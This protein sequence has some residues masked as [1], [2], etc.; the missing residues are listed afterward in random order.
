MNYL[1]KYKEY[2]KNLEKIKEDHNK[3]ILD[4]FDLYLEDKFQIIDRIREILDSYDDEID[5]VS[6]RLDGKNTIFHIYKK[7]I[8]HYKSFSDFSWTNNR[9]EK[10]ETAKEALSGNNLMLYI[11]IDSSSTKIIEINKRII[12]EFKS[13]LI[14]SNYNYNSKSNKFIRYKFR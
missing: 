2:V 1:E 12:S 14:L 11:F 6:L 8:S 3:K 9:E 7:E 13:D 5:D 10:L 4:L